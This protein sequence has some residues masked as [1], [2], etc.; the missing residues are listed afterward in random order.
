MIFTV[1]HLADLNIVEVVTSG[2]IDHEARKEIIYNSWTA[3]DKSGCEKL[4]INKTDSTRFFDKQ[5]SG[6]L[7][8]IK[9]MS[10]LKISPNIAIA[11]VF[12]RLEQYDEFFEMMAQLK[13]FSVKN[14]TSRDAAI[15]WLCRGCSNY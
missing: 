12:N 2:L 13:E 4:L 14:F 1:K 9:L 7:S 8:I 3:L 5:M 10:D 6:A 15:A 11:G